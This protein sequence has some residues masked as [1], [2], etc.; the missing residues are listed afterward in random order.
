MEFE[1][2]GEK[3]KK[4]LPTL[5][6][7]YIVAKYGRDF[8]PFVLL[9]GDLDGENDAIQGDLDD[10]DHFAIIV[11]LADVMGHFNKSKL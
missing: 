11:L 2:G 5:I 4:G 9:K 3:E 7:A 10:D 8:D 1:E 6:R